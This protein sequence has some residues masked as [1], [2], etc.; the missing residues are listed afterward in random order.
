[1]GKKKRYLPEWVEEAQS[2]GG[3]PAP[4]APAEG[5]FGGPQAPTGSP[6]QPNGRGMGHTTQREPTAKHADRPERNRAAKMCTLVFPLGGGS[7]APSGQT[8]QPWEKEAW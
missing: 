5:F 7:K 4:R 8:L 2:E 1:L 6:H 3:S